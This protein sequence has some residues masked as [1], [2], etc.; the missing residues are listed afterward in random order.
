[1]RAI[2][3]LNGALPDSESSTNAGAGP[4]REEVIAKAIASVEQ[5]VAS[6]GNT[7][8]VSA[9]GD[10]RISLF[11]GTTNFEPVDIPVG[12]EDVDVDAPVFL[13][14]GKRIEFWYNDEYRWIKA[15]VRRKVLL[16]DG[17]ILHTLY[18]DKLDEEEDVKMV[19]WQWRELRD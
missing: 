19:W 5:A 18:F 3:A 13:P 11:G 8:G 7:T 6:T 1:M 9:G 10:A 4:T 12:G 15:T 17:A 2:V 16:E 14:D